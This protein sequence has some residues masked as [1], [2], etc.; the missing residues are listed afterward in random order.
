[1]RVLVTRPGAD[2]EATAKILEELDIEPIIEPLLTVKNLDCDNIS[3][4]G[5]QAYLAT[6]SN[7]IRGLKNHNHNTGIPVFAVGEATARTARQAGFKIVHSADGNSS[8]LTKLVTELLDP[9][10]GPLVHVSAAIQANDITGKL[11][12]YGFDC[13]RAVVYETNEIKSF[14]TECINYLRNNKIDSILFFSP[15]TAEVFIKLIRKARLVRQC[16]NISAVCIS[17]AAA[18]KLAKISWKRVI[19]SKKPTQNALFAALGASIDQTSH[20]NET[21]L[22][23]DDKI[24][25]NAITENDEIAAPIQQRKGS[26]FR[27]LLFRFLVLVILLGGVSATYNLWKPRLDD[28]LMVLGFSSESSSEIKSLVGRLDKLE[29][30]SS[31][32][33]PRLEELET[34]RIILQ[35]RLDSTLKQLA[36]LEVSIDAIKEMVSAVNATKGTTAARE[37]LNNL[38]T[39]LSKLETERPSM[40]IDNKKQFGILA[41]Q[42]KNLEKRMPSSFDNSAKA[43]Q[44]RSF[45]IALGQLRS[46]VRQGLPFKNELDS[47]AHM[48]SVGSLV[49]KAQGQLTEKAKT[50]VNSLSTLKDSFRMLAGK[51]VRADKVPL[52]DSLLNRTIYR[53]SQ[54]L[55]WRRTDLLTGTSVEAIV[56]R[57]EL[58]LKN[59]DLKRAVEELSALPKTSLAVAKPWLD[60]ASALI[61]INTLLSSLQARAVNLMIKHD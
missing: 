52:E 28:F 27:K 22:I 49:Q 16:K 55:T 59:A 5:L 12:G 11:I 32:S 47:L 43:A 10:D 38:M 24:E 48:D 7:G 23:T 51:I 40:A 2:G 4:S 36:K 53:L 42:L 19:V 41:E 35:R 54:T 46:A 14:S 34:E 15:R 60:N 26:D 20:G 13:Q 30:Q 8:E 61:S 37:T 58:A 3:P 44:S 29:L 21:N 25:K 50:G 45:V 18:A 56:A 1:M 39:R 57:T 31:K 33:M 6:S 17:Q 9:N